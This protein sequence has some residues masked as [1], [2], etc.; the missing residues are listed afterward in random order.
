MRKLGNSPRGVSEGGRSPDRRHT[1]SRCRERPG[2]RIVQP[3]NECGPPVR[4]PGPIRKILTPLGEPLEPPPVSPAR[5][6]P[7]VWGELVQSHDNRDVFQASP[8]DQP[9]IDIHCL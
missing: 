1:A 6:P 7:S 9:V 5:D 2:G 3:G 4:E 8:E